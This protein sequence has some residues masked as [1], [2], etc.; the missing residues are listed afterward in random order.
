ML[1]RRFNKETGIVEWCLVDG[2]KNVVKWFGL[3]KP[4]EEEVHKIMPSCN[5]PKS[6]FKGTISECIKG[7]QGIAKCKN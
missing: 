7:M 4:T 3:S 5:Y 1:V 6:N 2:E